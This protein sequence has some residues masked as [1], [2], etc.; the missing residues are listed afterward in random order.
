M[1]KIMGFALVAF[2]TV[3]YAHAAD[4][5]LR[6]KEKSPLENL[7]K[8]VLDPSSPRYGKFYTPE[9]IRSLSGP[10]ERAYGA[11]VHDLKERGYQIVAEDRTGLF[12]TVRPPQQIRSAK[13]AFTAL[14]TLASDLVENIVVPDNSRKSRP[15]LQILAGH[16]VQ[17]GTM[18]DQIR[19]IYGFNPI[20]QKGI[21]G[22]GQHIAI[23]TYDGFNLGDVTDYYQ[24]QSLSPAPTVDVVRFNGPAPLNSDSAVETE[25]DAE[26]SGY[27]APGANIHVF[28]SDQNNDMGEV[29][30]F[31][32]ILDDNRAKIVNYSWGDCEKNVLPQHKADMDKVFARALAQG[33]NIFMASGDSGAAGCANSSDIVADWP[34]AHP[35]VIA[36]GG[37]T[38]NVSGTDPNET[39]WNGSG[40]GISSLYDLPQWQS[41]IGSAYVRRS[42]PDVSFN[43]DPASGQDAWVTYHN[44]SSDPLTKMWVTIGGTSIASPQWAGFMALVNEARGSKGSLGFLNPIIYGLSAELH[45]SLF[46]DVTGGSNGGFNAGAGWD[47][48]TGW[49]SMKADG[50][51]SFLSTAQ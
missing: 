20:Y 26:F 32:A 51:L 45:T 18:P 19:T 16:P 30:L 49:G 24:K 28:T 40:G 9:E 3:N 33:V 39:A 48:V 6:L 13:L 27:L 8:S 21:T 46:H 11:F 22:K 36:V 47:A 17:R 29:Q 43:A 7:A 38:L 15:R 4:V 42:F 44:D 23:A 37:T 25:V 31:N 14:S 5:L 2:L 10:D 50:L 34:A 1:K 41:Q 12:L 35:D